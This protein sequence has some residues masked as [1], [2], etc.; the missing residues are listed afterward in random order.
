MEII[1]ELNPPKIFYGP[2]INMEILSQ[3]IEKFL[4]RSRTVLEFTK[5]I[6]I[7]DSV[8]GIPRISSIHGAGLIREN[9]N[10]ADIHVSCSVR[11]RDRNINSTIQMATQSISLNV[12][13]LLFI[14]GDEPQISINAVTKVSLSKPTEVITI[15][16]SLGYNKLINLNLSIP[17]KV[18]DFNKFKKKT[19]SNPYAMIT[20]SIHS[21]QEVKDL[22]GLLQPH[23]IKLIPCV[24]IPSKKNTQAAKMIGLDWK[25]YEDNV[26]EFIYKIGKITEQILITSP[27]NFNEGVEV[28]R[29]INK[30]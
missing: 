27:N 14:M 9:I 7:T 30:V 6:H 17:N 8:L 16:N 5:F 10:N 12:K 20:Q 25:E 21:L 29:K 2:E 1:Y 26:L 28:L 23:N 11:T 22:K 24:M 13:D 4:L 18:S 15:L 19:K 3:E